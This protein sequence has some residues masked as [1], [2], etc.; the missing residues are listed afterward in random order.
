ME[1]ENLYHRSTT[2]GDPTSEHRNKAFRSGARRGGPNS[3]PAILR[4]RDVGVPLTQDALEGQVPRPQPK[5][6]KPRLRENGRID[7]RTQ[8]TRRGPG[9]FTMGR[10][11]AVDAPNMGARP[12]PRNTSTDWDGAV[13]ERNMSATR[14]KLEGGPGAEIFDKVPQA[15]RGDTTGLRSE[16]RYPTRQPRPGY[17]K[18]EAPGTGPMRYDNDFHGQTP[19][20]NRFQHNSP[21]VENEFGARRQ[22][23]PNALSERNSP[24]RRGGAR[25]G[26]AGRPRTSRS[27]EGEQPRRRK[28]NKEA[29]SGNDHGGKTSIEEMY[30]EEEKE[31]IKQKRIRE[32]TKSTAYEPGDVKQETFSGLCPA[33]VSGET[34]MREVLGGKLLLARRFLDREH[35]EWHSKEQKADV[36][37]L[38]EML[39]EEKKRTP[40]SSSSSS[41]DAEAEHETQ[42]LMQKLLGGRY[43]FT[44]PQQEKD[45]LGHV[46]RHTDRNESYFPMDQQS[47]L[48]K[49]RSLMPVHDIRQNK[50][51]QERKQGPLPSL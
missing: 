25:S 14:A 27:D 19:Q 11:G 20:G 38:V 2:K 36:M 48:E 39:K 30:N 40:S 35:V 45:I 1:V 9:N 47:L 4:D 15:Y 31:Y 34:G 46:A 51:A 32:A 10:T 23:S 43:E 28:R 7:T 33:V 44:K 3:Q 50:R 22:G 37:T 21:R 41:V 49:V 8:G 29:T 6:H 5:Q 13:V 26:R 24:A 17:E 42:N 16:Q 18:S 12:A